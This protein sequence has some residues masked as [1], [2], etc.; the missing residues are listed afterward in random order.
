MVTPGRAGALAAAI[1]VATMAL[2]ACKERVT[3]AQCDELLQRFAT[4]V[5]NEKMPFASAE[6]VRA[7]QQHERDESASDD[8]FKH[9]TTELRIEEYRCAVAAETSDALLKCLE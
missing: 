8:N 9:C 6:M 2:V 7:E 5:V 1:G 4:L 3:P